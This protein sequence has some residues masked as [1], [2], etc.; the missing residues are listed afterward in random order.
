MSFWMA[1]GGR[2]A[3][4]LEDIDD[5]GVEEMLFANPIEDLDGKFSQVEVYRWTGEKHEYSKEEYVCPTFLED[6]VRLYYWA[7]N[8]KDYEEAYSYWGAGM[9]AR[10]S[11]EDF[12]AGFAN[13]VEVRII[14]QKVVEDAPD[15]RVEQVTIEATDKKGDETV[16]SRF[17]IT[18]TL[19]FEK[20]CPKLLK[21]KVKKIE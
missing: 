12:E 6:V 3:F 7:I 5:D 8:D 1:I 16:I 11:Y 17:S 4:F 10:Q 2:G 15:R 19:G 13:T 14:E 20:G 21:A 9:Q 18:W